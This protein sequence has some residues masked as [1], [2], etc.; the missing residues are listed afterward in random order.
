MRKKGY[1]SESKRGRFKAKIKKDMK[2]R[3]RERERRNENLKTKRDS[4]GVSSCGRKIRYPNRI[5]A[6]RFIRNHWTGE[7]LYCY[8]CSYCGGWHLT[9]HPKEDHTQ[10]VAHKN[11]VER[12]QPQHMVSSRIQNTTHGRTSELT[13][14]EV[15]VAAREAA[16]EIRK[17]E[18]QA[19]IRREL[20]GPQ[21]HGYEA[22]PKTGIL[23]PMRHVDDLISWEQSQTN[24]AELRKPIEE[25]EEIVDG[26]DRL[27]DTL[28]TEIVS[29]YY[30]KAESWNDIAHAMEPMMGHRENFSTSDIIR[31]LKEA[32]DLIIRE[33]ESIGIANL[34]ELAHEKPC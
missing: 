21:G 2:K 4:V 14:R 11:Y 16:L 22:H 20:I 26:I 8:R 10:D 12:Q 7:D 1:E 18:E 5:A 19:E 6:E 13:V 17:I 23:D 27:G 3:H 31:C 9:S 33:W 15:L 24:M 30:L 32:L 25:A 29:R 28:A 34:K